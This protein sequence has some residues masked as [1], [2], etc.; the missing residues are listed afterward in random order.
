MTLLSG[1]H[2]AQHL[3]LPCGIPHGH[4]KLEQMSFELLNDVSN[5]HC[6]TS[7]KWPFYNWSMRLNFSCKQH[8]QLKS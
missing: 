7:R 5:S 8:L 1:F 2:Y 4:D 6:I 3:A